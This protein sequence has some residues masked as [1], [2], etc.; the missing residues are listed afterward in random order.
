M[1]VNTRALIERIEK[2]QVEL[3]MQVRNKPYEGS[4]KLEL[5]GGRVEEFESLVSALRR[6]VREEPGLELMQIEGLE[7]RIETNSAEANVECLQPFAVYQTL[8]GP[9]DSMGVYFRCQAEGQLLKAGDETRQLRWMPVSKIAWLMDETPEEI[10][11]VDRAGLTFYLK[12]N[13]DRSGTDF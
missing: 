3:L 2:G 13:R 10:S 7:T 4:T 5:P 12:A 6:E 1:Y 9:V 11:F 8:H